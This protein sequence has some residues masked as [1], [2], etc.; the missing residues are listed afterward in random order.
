MQYKKQINKKFIFY[1]DKKNTTSNER[2]SLLFNTK[3]KQ[4]CKEEINAKRLSLNEVP[5]QPLKISLTKIIQQY[6]STLQYK[7]IC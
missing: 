7:M 5:T 6:H 4:L 3:T 1:G 2:S